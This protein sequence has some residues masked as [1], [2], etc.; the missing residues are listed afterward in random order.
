MDRAWERR[1][2][3]RRRQRKFIVELGLKMDQHFFHQHA[4]SDE[5]SVCFDTEH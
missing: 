1:I 5:S 4:D 2:E 3:F